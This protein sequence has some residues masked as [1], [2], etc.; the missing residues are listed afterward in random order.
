MLGVFHGFGVIL[1]QVSTDS[2]TSPTQK[3]RPALNTSQQ[4]DENNWENEDENN[5]PCYDGEITERTFD[6]THDGGPNKQAPRKLGN[7]RARNSATRPWRSSHQGG[8]LRR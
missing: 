4:L 1:V 2:L 8:S 3:M 5:N 6:E 7:P